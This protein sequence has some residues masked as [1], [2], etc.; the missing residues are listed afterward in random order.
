MINKLL[1]IAALFLSSLAYV[2]NLS[3]NLSIQVV[4]CAAAPT[5]PSIAAVGQCAPVN[6]PLKNPRKT[7][8]FYNARKRAM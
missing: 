5:S 1:F 6:A 7:G 3:V 2:G 8:A 4:P